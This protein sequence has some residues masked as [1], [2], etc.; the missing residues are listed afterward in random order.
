MILFFPYIISLV[1]EHI[2]ILPYI[3]FNKIEISLKKSTE[4]TNI[5]KE[6]KNCF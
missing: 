4:T 3:N 5:V 6:K 2:E 1:I